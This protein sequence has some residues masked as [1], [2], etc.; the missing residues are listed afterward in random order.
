MENAADLAR[1][2]ALIPNLPHF[3]AVW[4]KAVEY[5]RMAHRRYLRFYQ[6]KKGLY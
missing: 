4:F 6:R 5:R 3:G 2:A 1:W